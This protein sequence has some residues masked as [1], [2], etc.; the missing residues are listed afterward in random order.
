MESSPERAGHPPGQAMPLTFFAVGVHGAPIK[1]LNLSNSARL[2]TMPSGADRRA[3]GAD[4]SCFKRCQLDTLGLILL[5]MRAAPA[6][7][8]SSPLWRSDQGSRGGVNNRMIAASQR[9]TRPRAI[10]RVTI[11]VHLDRRRSNQFRSRRA[12]K[13]DSHDEYTQSG[14]PTVPRSRGFGEFRVSSGF[15][16]TQP[17]TQSRDSCSSTAPE[18]VGRAAQD[19]SDA[20]RQPTALKGREQLAYH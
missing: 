6:T 7:N 8:H 1:G 14:P 2:A 18:P 15:S 10:D 5:L 4:S 9:T 13:Y 12:Y 19:G 3:A 17:A 20:L 11:S 16:D